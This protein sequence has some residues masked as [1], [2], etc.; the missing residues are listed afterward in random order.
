MLDEFINTWNGIVEKAIKTGLPTLKREEQIIFRAY[1]FIIEVEMGGV[2]GALYNLSP[3]LGSDQ[4]HWID[5][6]HAAEALAT[7]GDNETA[8]LLLKAADVLENLPEPPLSTWGGYMESANTQLPEG[9]WEIIESRI[10][11]IYDVLES[12]TNAYL[13]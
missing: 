1:S 2:S 6:R 5:L 3:K 13:S 7:I 8:Q 11:D 4:H 10:P 9:F 12:Y